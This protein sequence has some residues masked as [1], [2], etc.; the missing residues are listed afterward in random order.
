MESNWK[1]PEESVTLRSAARAVRYVRSGVKFGKSDEKR[2]RS[3]A[4]S[5]DGAFAA[6]AE[7][8][9]RRLEEA[10]STAALDEQP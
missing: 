4:P 8:V 2:T 5:R 7:S 3:Y 9:E 10:C 1:K 6:R